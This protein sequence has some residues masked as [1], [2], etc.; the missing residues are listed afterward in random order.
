MYS[1]FA[2]GVFQGHGQAH[3]QMLIWCEDGLE[4]YSAWFW[5]KQTLKFT[6]LYSVFSTQ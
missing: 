2:V 1:T 5:A 3:N 6:T 4:T